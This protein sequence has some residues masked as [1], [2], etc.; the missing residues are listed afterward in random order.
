MCTGADYGVYHAGAF[1]GIQLHD[2]SN[3]PNRSAT[4]FAS[5]AIAYKIVDSMGEVLEIANDLEFWRIHLGH[6]RVVYSLS[7]CP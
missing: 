5:H 2:S 7:G 3:N 6:G 1:S 4:T